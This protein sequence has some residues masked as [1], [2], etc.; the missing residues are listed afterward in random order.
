MRCAL[1]NVMKQQYRTDEL[2][3][4]DGRARFSSARTSDDNNS[5]Y[6]RATSDRVLKR[7]FAGL[8]HLHISRLPH[9]A[10]PARHRR[11]HCTLRG[12]SCAQDYALAYGVELSLAGL[13]PFISSSI[14]FHSTISTGVI[15]KRLP[16]ARTRILSSSG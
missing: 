4:D 13:S 9:M 1:L 8:P 6:G 15:D 11:R 7:A 2:L 16:F 14:N 12:P 10:A 5:D 3:S